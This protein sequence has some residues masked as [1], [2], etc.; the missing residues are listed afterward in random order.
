MGA[1]YTNFPIT[2]DEFLILQ[3]GFL[4]WERVRSTPT[5]VYNDWRIYY[6]PGWIAYLRMGAFY[7]NFNITTT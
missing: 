3:A 5:S 1:F 4:I 6:F 2:T 7:T